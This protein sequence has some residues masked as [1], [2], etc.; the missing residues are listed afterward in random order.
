LRLLTAGEAGGAGT[1]NSIIGLFLSVFIASPAFA[2][3][4][5]YRIGGTEYPISTFSE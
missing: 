1:R 4:K 2:E 3:D 5:I